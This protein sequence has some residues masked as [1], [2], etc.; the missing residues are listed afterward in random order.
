MESNTSA[1]QTFIG[2][3][4]IQAMPM[5]ED[6]FA[7]Y[8]GKPIPNAQPSKHPGYLVRY[9]DGY[10]SWS[11]K[12]V[13]DA[14]YL[15]LSDPTRITL[16]EVEGFI[17]PDIHFLKVGLKTCVGH[18]N[19]ITGME[20]TESAAC[21]DPANYDEN[22]AASIIM[23]KV[24]DKVWYALG[25]LLQ[26]GK[27]GIKWRPL[28]PGETAEQFIPQEKFDTELPCEPVSRDLS[29]DQADHIADRNECGPTPGCDEVQCRGSMPPGVVIDEAADSSIPQQ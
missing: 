12:D 2:V 20:F 22:K 25:F 18:G 11:P 17:R 29:R 15:P 28:V 6:E 4:M 1:M 19:L 23:G 7:S 5:S 10:E 27:N 9:P 21:V 24:K 13:F 14:A 26:W 8:K 3:K 16:Q